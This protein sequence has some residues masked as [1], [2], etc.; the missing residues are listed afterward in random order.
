ME[1]PNVDEVITVGQ[2]ANSIKSML[3]RNN[4]IN[5]R[6]FYITGPPGIG[7]SV[8]LPVALA[9]EGGLVVVLHPNMVSLVHA[10]STMESLWNGRIQTSIFDPHSDGSDGIDESAGILLTTYSAALAESDKVVPYI[11][12]ASFCMFDE[13]HSDTD[14]QMV[15]SLVLQHH[16]KRQAHDKRPVIAIVT[17]YAFSPDAVP[18]H[19]F[20]MFGPDGDPIE[21]SYPSPHS[22]RFDRLRHDV[23][24]ISPNIEPV[25]PDDDENDFCTYVDK[26]LDMAPTFTRG[27]VFA[28]KSR[29]EGLGSVIISANCDSHHI[30]RVDP[31]RL[32]DVEAFE[33]ADV[34]RRTVVALVEPYFGARTIRNAN[35]VICPGFCDYLAYDPDDD[36]MAQRLMRL[37]SETHQFMVAHATLAAEGY[38]VFPRAIITPGGVENHRY[39]LWKSID[40][41]DY[42]LKLLFKHPAGGPFEVGEDG[43]IVIPPCFAISQPTIGEFVDLGLMTVAQPGSSQPVVSLTERGHMVAH[44]M[45]RTG[46][47]CKYWCTARRTHRQ[48]M[49]RNTLWAQVFQRLPSVNNQR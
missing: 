38:S 14:D 39:P 26:A 44:I 24:P 9:S 41:L 6:P 18:N 8:C 16:W 27:I 32:A 37:S 17:T 22:I 21:V 2:A 31:K 47:G 30:M 11:L 19:M 40:M 23:A 10:Q 34:T 48:Q 1:R 45:L 33:T 5:D 13:A 36:E 46:R 4:S 12:Q 35:W 20:D 42:S 49:H 28:P 25:E 7:K 29:S 43:E 3:Y 15:F